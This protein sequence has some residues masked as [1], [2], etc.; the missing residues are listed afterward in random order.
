M[1]RKEK[2]SYDVRCWLYKVTAEKIK[3]HMNIKAYAYNHI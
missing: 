3:Y 1:Y 2:N